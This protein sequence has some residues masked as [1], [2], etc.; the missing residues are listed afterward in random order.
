MEEAMFKDNISENVPKL[1][2]IRSLSHG[3]SRS[4]MTDI[5]ERRT[6]ILTKAGKE[7]PRKK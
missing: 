7:L 6:S 2:I 1:V 5:N 4:T 3:V